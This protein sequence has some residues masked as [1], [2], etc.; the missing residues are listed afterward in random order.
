MKNLFD[1][2]DVLPAVMV[3]ITIAGLIFYFL[4]TSA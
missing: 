4:G 2:K 1:T 3:V